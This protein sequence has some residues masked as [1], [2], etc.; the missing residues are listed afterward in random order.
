[1][2]VSPFT[3]LISTLPPRPALLS[4]SPIDTN[5]CLHRNYGV[6][7]G[8]GDGDA[9]TINRS[10]NGAVRATHES[11]EAVTPSV[12]APFSLTHSSLSR[13]RRYKKKVQVCAT[14]HYQS[15]ISVR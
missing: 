8:F 4:L 3:T 12:A 11:S 7:I 6:V 5:R 1:M 2:E 14:Y 10:E 15:Q 13:E 9:E